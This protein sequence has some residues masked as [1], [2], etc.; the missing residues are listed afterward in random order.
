M[1]NANPL[2][3]GGS[4]INILRNGSL[5]TNS[6]MGQ[7]VQAA[8]EDYVRPQKEDNEAFIERMKANPNLWGYKKQG[9]GELILSKGWVTIFHANG[10]FSR[11]FYFI[12]SEKKK[13]LITNA[14]KQIRNLRGCYIEI[15]FNN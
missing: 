5:V 14:L 11:S 6:R 2:T 9:T 8:E 7:R 10:D 4:R 13:E 15:S 1:L 12:N 3:T